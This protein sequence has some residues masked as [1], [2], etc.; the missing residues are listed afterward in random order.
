MRCCGQHTFQRRHVHPLADIDRRI[1]AVVD[2]IG[3]TG[4][5]GVGSDEPSV[6][7]APEH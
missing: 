2:P 3:T 7:V 6:A 5:D 1:L 4:S